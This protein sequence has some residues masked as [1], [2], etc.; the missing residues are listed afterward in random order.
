M[1][2]ERHGEAWRFRLQLSDNG[3]EGLVKESSS[4]GFKPT[5]PYK[6][7][8]WTMKGGARVSLPTLV[9]KMTFKLDSPNYTRQMKMVSSLKA[10]LIENKVYIRFHSSFILEQR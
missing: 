1:K 10:S 4:E 2:L 8:D 7:V 3:A 6:V 5:L 9:E